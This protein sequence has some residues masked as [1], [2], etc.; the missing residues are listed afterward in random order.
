L[1]KRWFPRRGYFLGEEMIPCERLFP[2]GVYVGLGRRWFFEISCCLEEGFF[3]G[4]GGLFKEKPQ[5][6]DV[7]LDYF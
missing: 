6:K 7:M 4:G 1:K 5:I 3:L 2:W